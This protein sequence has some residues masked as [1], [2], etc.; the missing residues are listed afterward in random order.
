MKK[1]RVVAA[2]GT[3]AF[4]FNLILPSLVLGQTDDQQGSLNLGCGGIAFNRIPENFSFSE[5]GQG[6]AVTSPLNQTA[7]FSDAN[8]DFLSQNRLIT[9]QDLRDFNDVN[10]DNN[11][12][13]VTVAVVDDPTAD[14]EY[15]ASGVNG[16]ENSIPLSITAGEDDGLL[17]G[18]TVITDDGPP[19]NYAV[20]AG[21]N[22]R[23]IEYTG[24]QYNG[25]APLILVDLGTNQNFATYST[26]TDESDNALG[27]AANTPIGAITLFQTNG[28]G[29]VA[30]NDN[31]LYGEIGVAP[32][33]A[34]QI[35]GLQPAGND[36][37]LYLQYELQSF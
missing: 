35:P 2:I 16:D 30:G 17:V 1:H 23:F 28:A 19:T 5:D 15:F 3:F 34:A 6:G 8:N 26:F 4:A 12:F 29:G 11:G 36:Y 13:S 27:S 18:T 20:N 37:T 21:V 31:A 24:T 22:G 9:V 10:C 14:G 33:Y 7:V 32:V 25:V